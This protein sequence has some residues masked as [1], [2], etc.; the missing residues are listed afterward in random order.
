MECADKISVP[1]DFLMLVFLHVLQEHPV[2][3]GNDETVGADALDELLEFVDLLGSVFPPVECLDIFNLAG[4]SL[5]ICDA[6]DG[7]VESILGKFCAFEALLALHEV[8]MQS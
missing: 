3:E 2:H 8:W 7:K 1:A 4:I 5:V 6:P